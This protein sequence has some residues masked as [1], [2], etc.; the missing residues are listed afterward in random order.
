M[1]PPGAARQK[2]VKRSEQEIFQRTDGFHLCRHVRMTTATRLIRSWQRRMF[3]A[4]TGFQSSNDFRCDGLRKDSFSKQDARPIL[5]LDKQMAKM[6]LLMKF[7][8]R[9]SAVL[10][11]NIFDVTGVNLARRT[12]KELS[13]TDFQTIPVTFD[14]AVKQVQIHQRW[15]QQNA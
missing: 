2:N 14:P 3:K 15:Y 13:R 1:L 10:G 7:V 11:I 12:E 5:Q 4:N 8:H 9:R 6:G